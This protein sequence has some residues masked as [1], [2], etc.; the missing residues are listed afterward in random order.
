MKLKIVYIC[1]NSLKKVF[2]KYRLIY[3]SL[4]VIPYYVLSISLSLCLI[5]LESRT[6]ILGAQSKI[7]M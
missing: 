4:F 2:V 1:D 5:P 7:E 6:T 3:T